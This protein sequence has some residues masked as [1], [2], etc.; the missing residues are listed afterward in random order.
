MPLIVIWHFC[1]KKLA[2][3]LGKLGISTKQAWVRQRKRGQFAH[4]TKETLD[5][6]SLEELY[7]I[8]KAALAATEY[9]TAEH[10]LIYLLAHQDSRSKADLCQLL[11]EIYHHYGN[12]NKAK[13]ICQQGIKLHPHYYGHYYLL[14]KVL[15]DSH[16][17]SAALTI[18]QKASQI[19]P[20]QTEADL[21]VEQIYQKQKRSKK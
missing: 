18:L 3:L 21:L 15:N 6:Y 9:R 2:P 1:W 11:G 10:I 13:I 8:A 12:L 7:Q 5:Q 14:G 16:E 20:H 17:Y 19:D 4:Y